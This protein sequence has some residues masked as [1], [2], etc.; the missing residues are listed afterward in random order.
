MNEEEF[1][2]LKAGWKQEILDPVERL[3]GWLDAIDRRV[4]AFCKRSPIR[5]PSTRQFGGH[6]QP[7]RREDPKFEA[8]I[9]RLGQ[10]GLAAS[11][12]GGWSAVERR[13]RLGGEREKK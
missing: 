5:S 8:E 4:D 3:N 13:G 12:G 10:D 2:R 7:P 9:S 1:G 6:R 11:P